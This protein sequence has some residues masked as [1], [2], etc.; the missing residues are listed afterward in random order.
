MSCDEIGV[1][2]EH[3]AS[4]ALIEVRRRYAGVGSTVQQWVSISAAH[5]SDGAEKDAGGRTGTETD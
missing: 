3:S 4:Y 1:M 2:V 5:T